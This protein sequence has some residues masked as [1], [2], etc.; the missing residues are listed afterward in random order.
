[1]LLDKARITGKLT[2]IKISNWEINQVLQL[3]PLVTI[4][5][6]SLKLYDQHRRWNE[7]FHT[8]VMHLVRFAFF[9]VS[10]IFKLLSLVKFG[11]TVV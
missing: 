9:A 10:F 2:Y 7:D 5:A 8:L 4:Y 3:A 1:M 11:K 6:E